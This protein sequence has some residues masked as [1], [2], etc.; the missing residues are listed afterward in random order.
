MPRPMKAG[1]VSDSDRGRDK[2]RAGTSEA[3]SGI[4]SVFAEEVSFWC[5]MSFIEGLISL[6]TA[7][8]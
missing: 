5:R 3:V 6:S 2:V 7:A 1:A 8:L 4:F